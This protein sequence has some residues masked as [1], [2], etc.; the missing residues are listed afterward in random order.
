MALTAARRSRAA[1]RVTCGVLV[2][3]QRRRL[4]I[5]QATGSPRWDIPKGIADSGESWAEA[6][7]RELREETGLVVDAHGLSPL[8][9]HQ[10]LPGKRL[11]LF[12]WQPPDM[13]DPATLRCSSMFRA[14]DGRLVPELARFAVLP[15]VEALARLGKN[16]ARVLG[17]PAVLKDVAALG[18]SSAAS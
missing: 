12:A 7:A 15:W 8:G 11:A 10:Y 4:L 18:N 16:M 9:V 6:A 13:P 3:D 17:D 2:L 14:R 5:G 1:V